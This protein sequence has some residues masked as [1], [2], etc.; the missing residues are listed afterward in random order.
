MLYHLVNALINFMIFIFKVRQ[1]NFFVLIIIP[2][3]LNNLQD[4]STGSYSSHLRCQCSYDYLISLVTSPHVSI[5]LPKYGFLI[6][7]SILS[8]SAPLLLLAIGQ[9][10]T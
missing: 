8:Q 5:E 4:L 1:I 2:V 10:S 6:S 3:F 9:C 7:F